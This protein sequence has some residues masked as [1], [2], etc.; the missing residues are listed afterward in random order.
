L[1][2]NSAAMAITPPKQRLLNGRDMNANILHVRTP[3]E[4]ALTDAFEASKGLLVGNKDVSRLREDSFRAFSACGLPH[5]HMESWHYTDLRA[6]M[7]DGLP[8][9]AAPDPAA[10]NALRNQLGGAKLPAPRLVLADGFFLPEFSSGLPSGLTVRPLS[11]VLTEGPPELIALLAAQDVVS[12]DPLVCLNAAL[13]QDGV[14]IEIAPGAAIPEPI[15]VIH[16]GASLAPVARF[17]RSLLVL[18]AGA[19]AHLVES[20]RPEGSVLAPPAG[21]TNSCLIILIGDGATLSHTCAFTSKL[22]R[23]FCIE[24]VMARIGAE[25]NFE[26]FALIS[27]IGFMRR[28]MFV[29]FEGAQS[30]ARLSGVS[31]LGG[32][33]HADT[34]VRVEHAAQACRSRETFRYILDDQATGVFQGRI[35]VA[36]GAQKTDGKMLCKSIL[37]SDMATMNTKP[38]LEIFADDVACGHGA[39]CGGLDADQ[40]FYLQTRGLPVAQAEALMLEGFAGELVDGVQHKVVAAQLR[41]AIGTWL[42][43][44]RNSTA[45]PARGPGA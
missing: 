14:V 15:H 33:E 29:R 37:L 41:G 9:A 26:S 39:T 18:G 25:A 30:E 23:S 1:N 5:R 34:T 43:G 32:R 31:L 40:L 38:E 22:P 3:A 13:M 35:N 19:S 36:Q 8:L 10:R 4:M 42:A 6:L 16:A 2:W 11:S 20:Y 27:G 45:A 17:C 44:R 24:S 21:Q 28:Q 7:R 12:Q